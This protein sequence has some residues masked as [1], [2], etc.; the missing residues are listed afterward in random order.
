[1]IEVFK[2]L[3]YKEN[4]NYNTFF[5]L[6]NNTIT[7]GHDLKLKAKSS[8]KEIRKHFF[9][10]RVI[11]EWNGLPDKVVSAPTLNSF[12]NRLDS[13]MGNAKYTTHPEQNWCEIH[14]GVIKD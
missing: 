2:L 13:Y 8:K 11:S 3:N 7:R 5:E 14:E 10:V 6:N 1:M 9:S 4:I 12:K